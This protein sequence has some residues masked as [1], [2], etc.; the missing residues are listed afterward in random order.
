[1]KLNF[2]PQPTAIVQENFVYACDSDGRTILVLML[3]ITKILLQVFSL[4]L[5]FWTRNVKV[6]G[7]DDSKYIPSA[8]YVSTIILP[9]SL[10]AAIALRT[11]VNVFPAVLSTVHLFGATII[12]LIV[13]IPKIRFKLSYLP[14]FT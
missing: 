8:I 4:L 10:T 3:S 12:L 2:F 14:C 13:F 9:I 1:M 6:K 5:T 11:H 7:L